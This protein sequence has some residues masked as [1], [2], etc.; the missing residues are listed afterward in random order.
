[1]TIDKLNDYALK[2]YLN[3]NDLEKLEINFYDID[4]SCIKKLIIML[5]DEI[6]EILNIDM[7][8]EKL[9]VEVFAK[10][11]GCLIF[12]SCSGESQKSDASGKVLICQFEDFEKLRN[13]CFRLGDS[14]MKKIKFSQLYGNNN[15]IRLIIGVR[16]DYYILTGIAGQYCKVLP[17][18]EINTGV[19]EEYFSCIESSEAIQK[20]LSLP[21]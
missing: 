12:I 21:G 9:Y 3:K 16:S 10:K 7:S 2:I 19:T 20:V 15:H 6:S 17:G 14:Y 4:S 8:N 5:S 11:S 1:M 18:N 13:F